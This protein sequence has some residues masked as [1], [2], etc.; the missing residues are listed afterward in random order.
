MT[1]PTYL[2]GY[3]ALYA[4]NPRQASLAWLRD[5]KFGLFMHY[6]IYALLGRGEWV[7]QRGPVPLAEYEQLKERFT[8]ERFDADFITD[9]ALD[10]GMRYITITSRH[11]DS[12]CLFD[13]AQSDYSTVHAPCGR[14]LIGELGEQCAAKGLGY[15]LYYSYAL[16]WRH[17]YFYTREFWG[18][19]RPPY[20]EPE[21][22]YLW[23]RDEDFR[24]YID[25]V[26]AQLG[27]LL[28][29]YGPIAGIWFDPILG[30]YARPDLFP[31]EE[32]YA[33]IRS[34]QPQTLISFKQGANGDE[35]FYAPERHSYSLADRVRSILGEASAQVAAQAWEGNK[36]KLGE[37]CDTMQPGAWGYKADDDGAHHTAEEVVEMLAAAREQGC[38]LLLNTGPLPDGSIHPDDV[39]ALREAGKIMRRG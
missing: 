31:V 2:K 30:Y 13:T 21:P 8:A 12:F 27:E 29:G 32:T 22:R 18:A 14:D 11:H 34:L 28:T 19:A 25:F 10:A 20:E 5:S 36:N 33:L 38:N 24:H 15:F 23:K 37:I 4:E 1:V 35:D 9:L 6:G 7:Q 26:H 39:A 3:E 16:D 17:P